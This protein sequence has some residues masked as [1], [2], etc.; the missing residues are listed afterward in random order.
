M[1]SMNQ[2]R[3]AYTRQGSGQ[4]KAA[5]AECDLIGHRC[6]LPLGI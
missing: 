4:T 5:C 2:H 3:K 1:R 6:I